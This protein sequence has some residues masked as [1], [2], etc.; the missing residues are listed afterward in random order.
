MDNRR[1]L[2]QIWTENVVNVLARRHGFL[3]EHYSYPVCVG[4]LIGTGAH[5]HLNTTIIHRDL[6]A[7]IGGFDEQLRYEEDK[8]FYLRAIDRARDIRYLP[9][10]VARHNV[11]DPSLRSN[12]STTISPLEKFIC[13]SKTADKALVSAEKFAVR[14]FAITLK[15]Y[16]LKHLADELYKRHRFS[17]S[18]IYA[19]QALLIG[20][21]IRWLGFTLLTALRA[22]LDPT[23][24]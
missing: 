15:K 8:D 3:D 17:E 23:R 14:S 13:Q 6:F 18:A 24:P 11:P 4:D 22:L 10:Q 1:V 12:I 5:A 9:A 21:N 19:K 16:A 7:L 20:F 2:Q